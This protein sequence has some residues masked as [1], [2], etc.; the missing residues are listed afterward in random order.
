MTDAY[1]GDQPPTSHGFPTRYIHVDNYY[2]DTH[3]DSFAGAP[4]TDVLHASIDWECL[5]R[6]RLTGR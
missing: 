4:A 1:V 5:G 3:S 2:D 6:S